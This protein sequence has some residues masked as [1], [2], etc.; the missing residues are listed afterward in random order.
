MSINCATCSS[1]LHVAAVIDVLKIN[2]GIPSDF[3]NL[4]IKT[5]HILVN[6]FY[7]SLFAYLIAPTRGN[8]P[9]DE[10]SRVRDSQGAT[11]IIRTAR[12]V[13]FSILS[14]IT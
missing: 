13:S 11:I 1:C 10:V 5:A 6:K 3:S 2:R 8:E 7:S 14:Y 4:A 9:N 12:V